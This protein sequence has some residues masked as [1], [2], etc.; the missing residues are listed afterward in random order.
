MRNDTL[1]ELHLE[2][3]DSICK[4]HKQ[5]DWFNCLYYLIQSGNTT[6]S[7]TMVESLAFIH[8][9]EHGYTNEP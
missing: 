9:Y 6:D 8:A 3:L 1:Y 5:H 7:L 2:T 4:K